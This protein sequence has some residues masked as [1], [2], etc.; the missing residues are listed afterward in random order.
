MQCRTRKTSGKSAQRLTGTYTSAKTSST[1]RTANF[2]LSTPVSPSTILILPIPR[3]PNTRAITTDPT[4]LEREARAKLS[5]NGWF[6]ASSNAGQSHTHH[7]NRA[8]FARHR[9]LP[10]TLVDTNRRETRT[11]I[12]GKSIPAP[13]CFAPIGINEIY[14]AQAEL[15]VARVAGRLGLPYCLS[16]AGSRPV[17]S[18]GEANGEEGVR[19]FQLYMPH[20]DELTMSLLKRAWV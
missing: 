3:S 7:A 11:E 12:F 10:R 18:V 16:T 6:Y 1:P 19:W 20:D 8:A 4:K 15:A 13:I 17:E 14:H 5:Q 9:I 2:R